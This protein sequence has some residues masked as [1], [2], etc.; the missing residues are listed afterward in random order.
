[1]QIGYQ[2]RVDFS[3]EEG[4][5]KSA[6]AKAQEMLSQPI[7]PDDFSD[8]YDPK[9]IK[10]DKDYIEKR[11]QQFEKD[12]QADPRS[13][14]HKEWATIL[15]AILN[16]QI[17]L[18]EWLG[19]DATTTQTSDFDDIANGIDTI[20]TW[21]RDL[22]SSSLG[23]AVD[24][25]FSTNTGD[26]LRKIKESI[27]QGKLSE[28]KYYYSED[29]GFKGKLTNVPRVVIGMEI[30]TVKSIVDTWMKGKNRELG[31][32]AIQLLIIEEIV[33]QLR[34]SKKYAESKGQIQ[35]A[36]R[37]QQILSITEKVQAEKK[38]QIKT[39][40]LELTDTDDV[41]RSITTYLQNFEEQS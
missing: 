28:I 26:K 29:L 9:D 39:T 13:R 35:I 14:E 10:R 6:Y 4:D 16:Q 40:G 7:N 17:E 37:Y 15:E 1:M 27:D 33:V 31:Q 5:R 21:Q 38:Q 19:E 25:T 3:K 8:L 22:G 41:F 23:L 20:V 34:A 32:H 12:Y 30:G 2:E 11:K 18:N 36:D 24:V